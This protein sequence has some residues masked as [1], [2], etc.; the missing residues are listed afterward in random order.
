M[1]S[2]STNSNEQSTKELVMLSTLDN[3]F[4]P[5]ID[6]EHWLAFDREKGYYTNEYLARIV[7]STLEYSEEQQDQDLKE[8]ID[9]IVNDNVLGIYIKVTKDFIPKPI[10]ISKFLA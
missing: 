8:G 7:T 2:N 9:S 1:D 3:P 5:F 6:Y 4:N 10:D